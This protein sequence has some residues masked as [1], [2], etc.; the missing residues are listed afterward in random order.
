MCRGTFLRRRKFNMG[1]LFGRDRSATFRNLQ[2]VGCRMRAIVFFA[3]S[4][5]LVI[6]VF[7]WLQPTADARQKDEKKDAKD[8]KPASK[9]TPAAEA[10]RAKALKAKVSVSFTDARLGD[11]LKEFAA[12]VDMRADL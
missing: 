10:T 5:A 6:G 11:V 9:L 7:Q 4:A 2:Q 12:Q 3:L 8:T 1:K